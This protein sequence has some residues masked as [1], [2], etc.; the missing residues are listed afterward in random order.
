MIHQKIDFDK[1]DEE[2]DVD[3]DWVFL[4][5]NEFPETKQDSEAK[6]TNSDTEL[7][8]VTDYFNPSSENEEIKEP[9]IGSV[10]ADDKKEV[11]TQQVSFI[12]PGG[13]DNE[14]ADS[15]NSKIDVPQIDE[16]IRVLEGIENGEEEEDTKWEGNSGGIS[17]WNRR[18]SGVG[19]ICSF[20]FAAAAT[21]CVI[22]L[23]NQQRN[24][25]QQEDQKVFSQHYSDE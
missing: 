22:V 2:L 24:R 23:A 9:D 14:S 3:D 8:F 10:E 12:K 25:Q 5:D 17:F 4:S 11:E 13:I 21:F 19:A 7:V 6:T 1:I 15:P 20:G 16:K 18:L